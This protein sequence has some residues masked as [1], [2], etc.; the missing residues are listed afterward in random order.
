[1]RQHV[2]KLGMAVGGV[3]TTLALLAGCG[4]SSSATTTSASTT[5]LPAPTVLAAASLSKVFP[6]IDPAADYSFGGSGALA[7]QI[8]QGAPADVFAAASARQPAA[9]VAKGLI[10]AP[11]KFATNKVAGRLYISCGVFICRS[12]PSRIT[13]IR[14]PS[15][16]ASA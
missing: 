12:L 4:S 9:L 10:D 1:M 11:V 3:A 7:I 15:T 8:E 2:L 14:S 5:S 6:A 13:P 16:T